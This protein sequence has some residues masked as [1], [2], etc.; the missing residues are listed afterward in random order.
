MANASILAAFE[1]MWQ[2]IT[3]ALSKKSDVSH[4]HSNATQSKS[5]F[6][7]AGDKIQLDN[8]GIPIVTAS[9]SDGITYTAT[10]DGMTSLTNGAKITIVPSANSTSTTPTLN[11]NSLGAKYIRMPIT[12]NTSAS[13]VGVTTTWLTKDK[14]IV[15]EYDGT[16]W[17]T[18]SMPRPS[19]Q[20]LYGTVPIENGGTGATNSSGVLTNLGLTATATELNYCDGVTSNIQAQLNNKANS[21]H[22]H[23]KLTGWDDKRNVSTVPNEYNKGFII[24][25]LKMNSII[26]LTNTTGDSLYSSVVGF[27]SWSD[28]TGG[29]AHELAFTGNGEL[30]R[31]SGETT[32]WGNWKEILDDGNYKKYCTPLNIGALPSTGGTVTGTLVL[33]KTQDLSGKNDNRPALI[34]GGLPTSSHMEIDSNEIQSKQTDTTVGAISINSDGGAIKLGSNGTIQV[35]NQ[36][37]YIGSATLSY[38]STNKRLVISVQ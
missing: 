24:S 15:V 27:R 10:V 3:T 17:K 19:A 33:S 6:L 16:Y 12:Y 28:N 34:V 13:S 35:N 8:G 30:Y 23:Y 9:S 5:G 7:S 1:R 4:T 25:G 2:H 38:D 14:P 36:K 31:R 26:N 18:I 21:S 20:Y 22:T 11:V 32:S 37:L 29:Q